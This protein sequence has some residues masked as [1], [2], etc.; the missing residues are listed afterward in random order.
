[1]CGIF[2][3]IGQVNDRSDIPQVIDTLSHRGP[4]SHGDYFETGVY[5][6]HTRLSIQDISEHGNQPMFSEDGNF[7]IIFNGEIYNHWDLR[8]DLIHD[9]NFQST[10]DTETVLYAYIK[11]GIS[12]L[13]K[14]NGIFALAILDRRKKEVVIARDPFGVKP[15]YFYQDKEKLLFSSEIKSFLK[16]EINKEISAKAIANYLTFSWSPGGYTP[17]KNVIKIEPGHFFRISTIE[18]HNYQI[19]KFYQIPY[20]GKYSNKSEEELIEELEVKLIN[21]VKRQLLSDVPVGFFLSGGLDSSLLVAIAKKI[22]PEKNIECFTIDTGDWGRM[23]GFKN[24]LEYAKEIASYLGVS[25]NII[26]ADVNILA[27]FDKMIWHLDEPQTDAAPLNVLNI[28][29]AAKEKG[30]KVLI[31]GTAGDD[32]LS[33]YRRH[34]VINLERQID[35][36]PRIM[37]TWAKPLINCLPIRIPAV[38]R[39]RRISENIEKPLFQRLS[40]YFSWIPYDAMTSLLDKEFRKQLNGYNPLSH[41]LELNK[42][43]PDEKSILNQVLFW[44]MNTFLVDHNLNYTDKLAMACGVEVRVPYLDLELVNFATTIPPELKLKGKE[45]K[46]ILKKVAKRYLPEEVIYRPKTGFGAPMRKWILEDLDSMIQNRL[47]KSRLDEIGIFNP[48]EVWSLINENKRGKID[49]SFSIWALLAIES[50]IRQFVE[51]D[52]PRCKKSE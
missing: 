50:W 5:L 24:D 7:V 47:S 27:D 6:G 52:A 25:L 19:E 4:D 26:K 40:G 29:K 37:R 13:K 8:K 23:E 1:M 20:S 10:S 36:I 42:R 16:F 14:L 51:C 28:C 35:K 44:E 48:D 34:R 33:G 43:I 12:F 3:Y 21:S 41:F 38:R 9:Y 49:G 11:Y 22:N 2:G 31:G 17:F 18:F 15:L 39:V 30:I 46:Y 32:L 45:T